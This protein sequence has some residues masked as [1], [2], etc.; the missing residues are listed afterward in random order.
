MIETLV[1][2]LQ[3]N[4]LIKTEG[5][6]PKA[7]LLENKDLFIW[8][9]LYQFTTDEI[10]NVLK[11][12]FNFHPLTIDNCL[13]INNFP[14]IEEYNDYH[15]MIMN[16]TSYHR[17]EKN[18]DKDDDRAMQINFYIGKNY[19]V[20]VHKNPI[21]CIT[22]VMTLCDKNPHDTIGKGIDNLLYLIINEVTNNFQSVIEELGK[23]IKLTKES[24]FRNMNSESIVDIISIKQ[25]LLTLY[26]FL[27][28]HREIINYLAK[29]NCSK[30][31][32]KT[33]IYFRNVNDIINNMLDSIENHR[34]SLQS[35][36][37]SY[38]SQISYKITK[39][40]I[41]M[42]IIIV[43]LI[44]TIITCFFFGI[45]KNNLA[46]LYNEFGVINVFI[47]MFFTCG[48]IIYLLK[49]KKRF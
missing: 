19:L 14:K 5:S 8:I 10:K 3:K 9:N 23:R 6:L 26:R 34:E 22:K 17:D 20:T 1:Y 7:A 25:E 37:D 41:M 15:F 42:S 16:T 31:S 12:L 38:L 30:I 21:S 18:I 33:A 48:A 35:I 47:F 46:F 32:N 29:G 28:P 11:E 43:V 44:P 45:A 24:I 27:Y 4:N 49:K 36:Q 2:D 13:K 39:I 40:I